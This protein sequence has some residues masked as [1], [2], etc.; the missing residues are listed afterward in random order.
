MLRH[1]SE[2]NS[3]SIVRNIQGTSLYQG[4]TKG[5]QI[6]GAFAIYIFTNLAYFLH[7]SK[8]NSDFAPQLQN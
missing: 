6:A 4:Y 2:S 7:I 1:G 3:A 8:K 5:I